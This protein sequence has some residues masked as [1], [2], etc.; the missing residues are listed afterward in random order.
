MGRQ[1]LLW[2]SSSTK[3]QRSERKWF[4]AAA[5]SAYSVCKRALSARPLASALLSSVLPRTPQR[6]ALQHNLTP[7]D[8]ATPLIQDR[9][10]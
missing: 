6:H 1:F 9:A 2:P 3:Q 7:I 4:A 5:A 10:R 8:P